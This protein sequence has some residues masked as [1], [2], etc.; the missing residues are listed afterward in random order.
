M[1]TYPRP[2]AALV[3]AICLSLC[4]V[5]Q[6]TAAAPESVRVAAPEVLPGDSLYQL[7]LPLTDQT[8]ATFPF[9]TLRGRLQLVS[10]FYTSCRYVCP[11]IIDTLKKTEATLS[12][13]QRAQLGVVVVSFDP[14]RDDVA[15]LSVV[16]E[17]RHLDAAR[18]HLVRADESHVRLLAAALDIQYRRLDDGEFNHASRV[19]LLDRDGRRIAST[20]KLGEVD[21]VFI[22][23]LK[24]AIQ[25]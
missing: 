23:A 21:P 25:P 4:I 11:L 9:V 17:K 13:A 15:A 2:V 7:D 3:G 14:A 24:A 19:I 10:M 5:T 8:G 12:D 18:W 16:A 20:G 22:A 1:P 6:A